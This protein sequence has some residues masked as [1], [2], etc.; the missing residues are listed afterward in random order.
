[1]S[2]EDS[3]QG[4]R[5][6]RRGCDLGRISNIGRRIGRGNI[7]RDSLS[8]AG[9]LRSRDGDYSRRRINCDSCTPVCAR[10]QSRHSRRRI[11]SGR[12]SPIQLCYAE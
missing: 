12:N 7:R 5:R 1:L 10:P 8:A 6:C 4:I 11:S 9:D 2:G 3:S